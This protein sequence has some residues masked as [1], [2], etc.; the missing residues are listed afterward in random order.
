MI[1]ILLSSAVVLALTGCASQLQTSQT[2]FG[3]VTPYRMELVQGNVITQE[4]MARVRPGLNRRQVRELLGT[5]LLTDTFHGNRWDYL[6]VIERQGQAPQRRNIVLRFD[7][8]TLASIDA[9]E[10]PTE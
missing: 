6:F 5:P 2:L 3:L 10:L 4:Q 7:G 1:R 9:G 8:D